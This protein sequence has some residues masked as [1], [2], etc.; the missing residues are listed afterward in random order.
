MSRL[1]PS[2]IALL[3]GATLI[4]VGSLYVAFRGAPSSDMPAVSQNAD[5]GGATALPDGFLS[6]AEPT[7]PQL[8]LTLGHAALKPSGPLS[9]GDM[10]EPRTG[11]SDS[12]DF[13]ASSVRIDLA[14]QRFSDDEI[15][16]RPYVGAGVDVDGA[17]VEGGF[18]GTDNLTADLKG[19]AEIGT[20]VT[21][22]EALEMNLGY[23]VQDTLGSTGGATSGLNHGAEEQVQGGLSLKF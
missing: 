18:L 22:T 16:V 1:S 2:S 23:E 17:G 7:Q 10:A 5:E 4:L 15:V 8:D 6:A 3:S 21:I 20:K 13:P 19:K 11:A 14:P 9:P 12:S